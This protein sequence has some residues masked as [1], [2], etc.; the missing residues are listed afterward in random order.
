[1]QKGLNVSHQKSCNLFAPILARFAAQKFPAFRLRKRRVACARPLASSTAF[2]Q[3]PVQTCWKAEPPD[4]I[5]Y[6]DETNN[7]ITDL[8]KVETL[9]DL[10]IKEIIEN[11]KA[12]QTT[13]TNCYS[14]AQ[15]NIDSSIN[16]HAVHDSAIASVVA[17]DKEPEFNNATAN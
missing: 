8:Y 16:E 6:D 7:V 14:Y 15:S 4:K 10:R 12:I 17:P 1:M 3:E 11:F 13:V 9:E 5:K 2:A